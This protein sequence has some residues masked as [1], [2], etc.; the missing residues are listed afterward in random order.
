MATV[1]RVAAKV[2][3]ISG[4]ARGQGR[5][6]AIRLAEEGADI[7]ALDI[8]QPIASA[9]YPPSSAD[10]LEQ[11]AE[12]VRAV[13]RRAVAIAVDVRDYQAVDTAIG[14]GVAELGR[15]DI[16]VVNHGIWSIGRASEVD[17]RSW[18][19]MLDVNLTGVWHTCKA[20]IPHLRATGTGG[21]IILTSS[22]AGLKGIA[23]AAH[24][25]AAKHGV[26]GLMRAMANELAAEFIRVNTIHTT[27]VPTPMVMNP[28]AFKLFRPDL[29]NPTLDDA[30][31]TFISHNNI[32]VPW[33]EE[34]DVSNAVLFLASDEARYVTGVTLPVDTGQ[35]VKS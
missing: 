7:I 14:V 4:A 28:D 18:Q 22:T 25:T 5:S 12:S 35:L 32:P 6:H 20:A 21:S 17:E 11:T 23:N 15:L 2:A 8:C 13:G 16:V 10:D 27:T 9:N 26:V 3:V 1:G 29:E 19:E 31:V 34:R 33:V 24:Y 30:M